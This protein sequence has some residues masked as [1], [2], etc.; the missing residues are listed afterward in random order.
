[1]GLV[2]DYIALKVGGDALGL[3]IEDLRKIGEES[4]EEVKA[5]VASLTATEAPE[6]SSCVPQSVGAGSM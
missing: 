4:V 3:S 1:M 6:G 2:E 5:Y